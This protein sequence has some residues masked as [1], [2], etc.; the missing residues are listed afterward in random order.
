[1]A[2]KNIRVRL[3]LKDIYRYIATGE[4]VEILG[5]HSWRATLRRISVTYEDGTKK[6]FYTLGEVE[7]KNAIK[8]INKYI[9]EVH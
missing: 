7:R 8:E 3:C 9:T 5:I 2:N 4:D 1:M 6:N